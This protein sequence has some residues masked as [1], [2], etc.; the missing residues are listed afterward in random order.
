L[1]YALGLNGH[2]T[3]LVS[4]TVKLGSWPFHPVH[5][6]AV[7]IEFP[8][9]LAG[10]P[11][12]SLALAA[13]DAEGS[14]NLRIDAEVTDTSVQGF[15]LHVRSWADSKTWMVKVAYFA[16][17]E[18]DPCGR[19]R[20]ITMPQ[21]GSYPADPITSDED[22]ETHMDFARP[23]SGRNA[24]LAVAGIAMLDAEANRSLRVKARI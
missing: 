7:S 16:V 2:M 3:E 11:T 20:G 1:V 8:T 22:R 6:D 15:R 10:V 12:I 18:C 23:L 14:R 21:I 17:L 24:P 13:R 9:A 19:M 5:D 4:G